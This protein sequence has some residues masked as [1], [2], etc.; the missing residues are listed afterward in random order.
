[1][2]SSSDGRKHRTSDETRDRR[3]GEG[4]GEGEAEEGCDEG[5]E[6]RSIDVFLA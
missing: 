2:T 3:E 4:E 1:M 6:G 5:E